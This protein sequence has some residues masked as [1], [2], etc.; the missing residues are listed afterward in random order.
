MTYKTFCGFSAKDLLKVN[1]AMI[2]RGI[3][4]VDQLIEVLPPPDRR[5]A[6]RQ[7]DVTYEEGDVL[8]VNHKPNWNT[9]TKRNKL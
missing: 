1:R 7:T 9:F 3:I 4:T 8:F 5:P 2:E 6:I